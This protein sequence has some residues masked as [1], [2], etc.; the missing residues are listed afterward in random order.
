MGQD[1][2][3]LSDNIYVIMKKEIN[4]DDHIII[5][6]LNCIACTNNITDIF[7]CY[8]VIIRNIGRRN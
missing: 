1:P 6:S 4:V 7:S 2:T 8:R 5:T 3:P